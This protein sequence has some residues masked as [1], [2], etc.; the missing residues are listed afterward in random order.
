[1][2]TIARDV[3]LLAAARGL[4]PLI[5]AES[6]AAELAGTMTG[7]VVDALHDAGLFGLMIPKALGGSEAPVRTVLEVIEEVSH[8]DGSTGWSHMANVTAMSM[9][10]VFTS[11]DACS[12]IFADAAN[13]MPAVAGMF[14]PQGSAELGD[15][16]NYVVTGRYGF[17]SGSGHA[18]WISGGALVVHKGEFVARADGMPEMRVA[19]VP[20]DQV[21]FLDNWDVLG[22]QGT[23][24]YDYALHDVAVDAGFT[25]PLLDAVPQRG[26]PVYGLNVLG[27]TSIGHAGFALGV[28]RRGLDEI[29]HIVAGKARLGATPVRDQQLFQYELGF[30]DAAMRAA[31]AV[32]F[33]SF[34]EVEADLEAG[35]EPGPAKR[36]RLRQVTTYA[37]RVAAEAV[38]FAYTWAGADALRQPSVLGRCFRDIHAG[39]QHLFVDNNTLSDA[40]A[41]LL[42]GTAGG[43]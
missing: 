16:G 5:E 33:E 38:R 30:H 41:M 25:F 6:D 29:V 43:D 19:F 23:G 26:G 11:D 21:E 10:A 3:D 31:R 18:S 13:R 14:A 37:T 27:I 12:T 34:D 22:L 8:A 7:P 9:A 42:D 17:A 20:R 15:D 1:M 4:T 35:R 36:G 39:T 28:G 2:T 32:V 40:G 24:S